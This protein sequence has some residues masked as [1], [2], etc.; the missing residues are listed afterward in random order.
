MS[1]IKS[2]LEEGQGSAILE[3]EIYREYLEFCNLNSLTPIS[4]ED[5]DKFV[6]RVFNKVSSRCLGNPGNFYYF[7]LKRQEIPKIYIK[8]LHQEDIQS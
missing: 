3:A 8:Y 7:G 1:W 4:A 5:F 2:N 6:K